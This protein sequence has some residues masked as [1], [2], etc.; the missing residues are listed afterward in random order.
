MA[1]RKNVVDQVI[2]ENR[3]DLASHPYCMILDIKELHP[4][5][6]NPIRRTQVVNIYDNIVGQGHIW[7]GHTTVTRRVIEDFS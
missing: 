4:K 3:S 7:Q 1:V 2:F 5:N 6:K